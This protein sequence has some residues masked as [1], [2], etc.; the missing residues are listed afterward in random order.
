MRVSDLLTVC[1]GVRLVPFYLS[2]TFG[3]HGR[4]SYGRFPG[5]TYHRTVYERRGADHCTTVVTYLRHKINSYYGDKHIYAKDKTLI[6]DKYSLD[7]FG[8]QVY[9]NRT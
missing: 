1:V 5:R 2:L 7:D 8:K 3:H 4:G 6:T 9:C